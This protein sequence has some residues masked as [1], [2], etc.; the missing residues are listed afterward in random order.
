V[1]VVDDA[2]NTSDPTTVIVDSLPPDPPRVDPTDGTIVYGDAEPGSHVVVRDADGDVLCETD[3]DPRTG[4]FSCVPGR[5]VADGEH[6]HVTAADEV[7]N[8]SRPTV[9]VV[10]QSVLPPP[11]LN[12]T[13]GERVSGEGLPGATVTVTFPN[14]EQVSTTVGA[15]GE[16]EVTAPTG[17]GP[18]HGDQITAIQS[19]PFNQGGAKVSPPAT[20]RVD[21][22]PPDAPVPTPSDGTTV[23]GTGEPGATVVVRDADGRLVGTTV[24]DA[25]GQW[26]LRADP[27]LPE[28]TMVTITQTDPAGNTS[29]PATL[30]IGRI[31]VIVEVPLLYHEEVQTARVE[32]LQPGERV[33]ATMFSNPLVLGPMEADGN[34]SAVYRFAIPRDTTEGVHHVE[35]TGVFSGSASSTNFTVIARPAQVFPQEV[36]VTPTVTVTA[37][38]VV[39]T[40]TPE[41]VVTPKPA[42]ETQHPKTG[43]EGMLAATGV[44]LGAL[45]A[46]LLL[47]LASA[48]RRRRIDEESS[49]MGAAAARTR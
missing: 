7:G 41:V 42:V 31:R 26:V 2:H 5:E 10:D 28:G 16:W 4:A 40:A 44:A 23:A 36:T 30:R 39:E 8:V 3:A 25:N 33:T 19:R 22:I 18:V 34:G 24:V 38:P 32:N 21:R 29:Q 27:T 49:E 20:V 13:N 15:D 48:K 47:I 1:V 45:L 17:Y 9:V 6:L 35:A 12:P 37:S 43:A 46:G 11:N 14:G